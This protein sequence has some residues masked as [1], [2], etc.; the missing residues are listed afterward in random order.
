MGISGVD[1]NCVSSI[2]RLRLCYQHE[3]GRDGSACSRGIALERLERRHHRIAE[4]IKVIGHDFPDGRRIDLTIF[5][6]KHVTD[7]SDARPR[8]IRYDFLRRSGLSEGNDSILFDH[9]PQPGL[10]NRLGNDID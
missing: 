1:C 8:L 10:A 5:V 7:R 4:R 2:A 6:S 3:N 9:A